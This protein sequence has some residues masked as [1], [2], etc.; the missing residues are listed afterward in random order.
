MKRFLV[1]LMLLV[2]VGCSKPTPEQRVE[3]WQALYM[4]AARD[5]NTAR[6]PEAGRE[7]R[8]RM[9]RYEY[10][11]NKAWDATIIGNEN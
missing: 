10:E 6:T 11:M 7:A 1:I 9:E 2:V 5:A 3:T 8:N 4:K